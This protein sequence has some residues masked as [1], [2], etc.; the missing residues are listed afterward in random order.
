[1]NEGKSLL[2]MLGNSDESDGGIKDNNDKIAEDE[3]CLMGQES[4]FMNARN[5]V[6]GSI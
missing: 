4:Q 6:S 1:M 5:K 3:E 2:E